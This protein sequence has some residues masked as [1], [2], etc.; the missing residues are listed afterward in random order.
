MPPFPKKNPPRN[1]VGF[2]VVRH[3]TYMCVLMVA[4]EAVVRLKAGLLVL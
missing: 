3:G 1:D 2:C 4:L